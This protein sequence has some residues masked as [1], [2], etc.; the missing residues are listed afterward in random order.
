MLHLLLN[1]FL[2]VYNVK[3][4][5]RILYMPSHGV[6]LKFLI[7]RSS[8]GS[9]FTCAETNHITKFVN[10]TIVDNRTISRI[11]P[12]VRTGR[13]LLNEFWKK[14]PHPCS[15]HRVPGIASVS[16]LHTSFE[17][18]RWR[19][20]PQSKRWTAAAAAHQTTPAPRTCDRNTLHAAFGGPRNEARM[21]SHNCSRAQPCDRPFDVI[22]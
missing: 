5:C 8:Y 19:P 2:T 4:Q 6:Y 21:L 3:L 7:F 16:R 20:R 17:T 11:F 10:T 18:D 14:N 13:S 12:A 1:R 9:S 22:Y 15:L